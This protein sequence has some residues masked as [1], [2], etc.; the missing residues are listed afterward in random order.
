MNPYLDLFLTFAQVG[1]CTF[2]GGYAMLPILQRE[3]VEKRGWAT[4]E[5][6]MD[7]YAVGQCTPG[8]IAVNTATFVGQKNRGIAGGIIA[9]LGVVFPSLVIISIIAAFIGNFAHLPAVQNAFAGVRVCVCVLIFNAVTKLWKKSVADKAGLVIF[10]AVFA[11]S[12][13]LDLSPVLYVLLAGVAG[14]VIKQLEV[15]TK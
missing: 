12:V 6:L 3:V 9:T 11:G 14:V 7:Y 13:L 15:R 10:L 4:E 1:V 8:V 5:E 2:G